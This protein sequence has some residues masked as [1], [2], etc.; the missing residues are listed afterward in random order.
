MIANMGNQYFSRAFWRVCLVSLFLLSGNVLRAADCIDVFANATQTSGP[1]LDLPAFLYSSS[2][3][4]Y[5]GNNLSFAAGEYK[6]INV[7]QNG[8]VTFTSSNSTYRINQLQLDRN[9]QAFFAPG[10]YFIDQLQLD[11][12]ADIIL[13]GSGTVRIYSNDISMDQS[14]NIAEGDTYLIMIA[15]GDVSIDRNLDFDGILYSTDEV[16]IERNADINGSI[17]ADDIDLGNNSTVNYDT[18]YI[19]NADFNGM[20]DASVAPAIHHI[21]ITTDGDALTCTSENVTLRACMDAACSSVATENVSVTLATTGNATWNSNPVTIPA[22]SSAGVSATLTNR[23]AE[24]VT[25]SVSNTTPSATDPLVCSNGSCQVT[26]NEAGYILSL[27]NHNSCQTG[28]LSIQAVRLSDNGFTCAPAYTGNQSVNFEF[29]YTNPA[30]GSTIPDLASAPMASAGATQSRTIN[31]DANAQADLDFSY[32]DAG[33]LT[34]TVSD[35]GTNGLS[36]ANVNT[37]VTP[38]QLLVYTNDA[39]NSCTGPDY[40]NCSE[41]RTAGVTGSASSEFNL[42]VAGAC[43]DNTVTPN[44]QLNNIALT[45]NLVAPA[46]GTNGSLGV[47]SVDITT[48]GTVTATQTYTEVG[49]ISVTATP[50]AYQGQAIPAA[51]SNTI[52]RFTPHRFLVSDNNPMLDDAT[53]D[54][55]YQD[56]ETIFATGLEPEITVTAVN[57]AGTTTANYGGDGVANND[58]WKFN[59]ADYSGRLYTNQATPYPGTVSATLNATTIAG[60]NNYDGVHTVTFDN[61]GITHDKAGVIPQTTNDAPFDA[62]VLLTLTAGSLTDTDGIFYDSDANGIADNYESSTIAGTNIRWG[63]WN[64]EN[65]YGSEL[66]TMVMNATAEYFDGNQF[67]TASTDNCTLAV[68]LNLSNYTGNLSS[69][70]TTASQTAISSGIIPISLTAP[71]LNNTGSVLITITTPSWLQYDY[72]G[73]GSLE[74]AQATATFGIYEGRRPVIIKRQTY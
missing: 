63:R 22:N 72:D 65:G 19:N 3:T 20:C 38:S 25:M 49:A 36:S 48:G 35:G 5:S 44:F 55:T 41:F 4:D 67:I 7:G 50:P 68:T 23:T 16:E 74:D 58:F 15:Y 60:Q 17:Y 61:D 46:T 12:G 56:Q 34:V 69:G 71:G 43:A 2:N 28:T 6:D 52:G 10:D 31:F 27:P 26:F 8:S 59:S 70:E 11:Q 32:D 21:E 53:C 18:D 47:T 24:T 64:L 66:Q 37:I 62:E 39:N 40:G 29:N 54:F 30:T 14:N 42:V 57:S 9:A 1:T 13:T 73:D 33:L 45:P 51:T